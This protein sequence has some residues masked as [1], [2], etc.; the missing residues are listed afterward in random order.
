M[1]NWIEGTLRVRGTRENI[2]RFLTEGLA[3]YD[4]TDF[5]CERELP[6]EEF[7]RVFD[8]DEINVLKNNVHIKNTRRAFIEK[9]DIYIYEYENGICLAPILARQAWAFVADNFKDLS[10]EFNV[11]FRFY[12][13]EKGMEFC[14]DVEIINGEITKD[15]EI[16]FDCWHWDCPMPLMGG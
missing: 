13:V 4:M 16:E 6:Q 8:E 1:P 5:P 7:L 15:N 10:K 11:D 12:G 14:Q 2:M 9:Q 3:Y